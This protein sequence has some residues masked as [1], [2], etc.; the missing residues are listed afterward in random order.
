MPTGTA[1]GLVRGAAVALL[2]LL[3]CPRAQGAF[4]GSDFPDQER[5]LEKGG[6]IAP[7]E[8]VARP[9]PPV[10]PVEH[11]RPIRPIRPVI[12][13]IPIPVPPPRG[14]EVANL[15]RRT[16]VGSRFQYGGLT[17]YALRLS[18]RG[19]QRLFTMD[20]AISRGALIIRE[21]GGGNVRQIWM[22][23]RGRTPV[24][25][26][27]GECVAGGKQDRLI[28]ED[29]VLAPGSAATI[30][31]YCVERGRWD[32]RPGSFRSAGMV[33]APAMRKAA[34]ARE[35]QARM[36]RHVQQ[37]LAGGGVSSKS[38]ALRELKRSGDLERRIRPY[39]Q[40][41]RP[42]PRSS[43]F[44]VAVV[45]H[46]RIVS[47]DIFS[48]HATFV[49]LWPRLLDSY[50]Y[51]DILPG[52]AKTSGSGRSSSRRRR[53]PR[54]VTAAEIRRII[55]NAARARMD[56]RSGAGSSQLVDIRGSGI[57]GYACSYGREAV[58]VFLHPGYQ[59]H[60]P[61]P[62]RPVHSR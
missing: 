23:N 7:S 46:G 58:H 16:S 38:E 40:A 39:R 18:G 22:E 43:A 13:P 50:A 30:P 49:A 54:D 55:S 27:G 17:L 61:P 42:V 26:L 33:A 5:E 8:P 47:I 24:F 53:R 1:A 51:A 41:F 48:S 12:R 15:L 44:G 19:G 56:W 52:L 20:E 57:T 10:R 28:A 11:I 25:L 3:L 4:L 36:W 45:R 2:I 62:N 60:I 6:R 37:D 32:K 14:N 9:E 31:V 35:S 29:A 21:S 34:G 59:V